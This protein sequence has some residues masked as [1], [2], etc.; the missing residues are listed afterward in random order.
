[1]N[2]TPVRQRPSSPSTLPSPPNSP[3]SPTHLP[4]YLLASLLDSSPKSLLCRLDLQV[5]QVDHH[6]SSP[7]SICSFGFSIFDN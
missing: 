4:S 2:T 3:S 5:K 1:M 6:C 7:R